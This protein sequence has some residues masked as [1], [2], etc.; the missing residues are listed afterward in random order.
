VPRQLNLAREI[1]NQA[2]QYNLK[3]AFSTK[4]SPMF[5]PLLPT[6]SLL[7]LL[8]LL[9]LSSFSLDDISPYLLKRTSNV[10]TTK[11]ILCLCF[12]ILNLNNHFWFIGGGRLRTEKEHRGNGGAQHRILPDLLLNMTSFLAL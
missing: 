10:S 1:T 12:C 5:L 4:H 8:I 7:K 3:G 6:S 9:Y 11:P 2:D